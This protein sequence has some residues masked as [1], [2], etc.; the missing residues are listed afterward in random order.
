MKS[1]FTL[2]ELLVV[3]AIIAILAG[4][5]LPALNKARNKAR[6]IQ[7]LNNTKQAGAA[8]MLYSSDFRGAYPVV[9]T[10]NFEHPEELPG[11]P[12]WHAP[13]CANYG[14]KLEFLKCPSDLGYDREEGIQSYMI[15]AM[16]T[17]GRPVSSIRNPSAAIVLAERG[18]ESGGDA[19][20]H[21]CYAG[22]SEPDDWKAHVDAARHDGRANYLF[23]DGHSVADTFNGTIGDGSE[24]ENKHFIRDWLGAYVEAHEH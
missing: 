17:F 1:R 13:L 18:F 8:L 19:V 20:E 2:I 6:A 9:H 4:M 22:M 5:L 21:Q 24:K 16:L 14:Y 7:C 23:V 10:G 11:E 15:N 12:Q 3:I